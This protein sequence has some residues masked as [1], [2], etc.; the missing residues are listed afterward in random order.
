MQSSTLAEI[1]GDG[2][3]SGLLV[4]KDVSLSNTIYSDLSFEDNELFWS[5]DQ[6][7]DYGVVEPMLFS[8]HH[9]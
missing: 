4:F 2:A 7:L 1:E 3:R 5:P 8:M 6:T 9:G